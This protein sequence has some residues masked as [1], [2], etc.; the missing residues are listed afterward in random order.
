MRDRWLVLVAVLPFLMGAGSAPHHPGVTA[1]TFRD[2]AIVESSA[3]VVVDGAFVTTNDSGDTGRVFTVDPATGRTTGVTRWSADPIDTEG[4]APAGHGAVWVGDIGD[5]TASRDTVQ[6]ARVPVGP[7]ERT[8]HPQVYDL[9]Y[10]DGAHNAETL[11]RDP[12]SGRLY[13]ATKGVFGGELYAAPDRLD[14]T[15]TNRLR[16]VA[17]VL[18]IATDGAF[19]PDGRHLILRDY[20]RAVVYSFPGLVEVGSFTLPDQDQG[21]GIAVDGAGRVFVS[22]EG[23]AEPVLQVR[24][25]AQLR[26]ALRRTSPSGSSSGSSGPSAAP[27]P[28]AADRAQA[29]DPRPEDRPVWPWFLTAW[30][31]LG[32][33]VM[34]TGWIGSRRPGD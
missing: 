16:P 32:G 2:P 22:S 20:G 9:A 19:F 17:P 23:Q 26:T 15:R 34:V 14:P 8:V 13:V 1:F 25:P 6:V 3:L 27:S 18:A 33:L 11:L 28:A 10:P 24:L 4:L 7:G 12:A 31:V 30:L 29:P 5:N 21:E